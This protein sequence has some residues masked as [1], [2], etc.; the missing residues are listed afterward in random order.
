MGVAVGFGV[1]V[2]VDVGVG[3]GV[4]V[5]VGVA[6]GLRFLLGIASEFVTNMDDMIA[7]I[8]NITSSSLIVFMFLSVM[9]GKVIFG[10]VCAP[11]A[12]CILNINKRYL[13]NVKSLFCAT[14]IQQPNI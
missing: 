14:K 10:I 6:V 8:A 4:D 12:N 3:L 5:G 7:V 1:D 13:L 2:G 11:N 9:R